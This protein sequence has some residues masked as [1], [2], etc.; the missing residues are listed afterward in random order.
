MNYYFKEEIERKNFQIKLKQK[1]NEDLDDLRK[2]DIK[3][4]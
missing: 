1:E 4:G 2:A 3:E